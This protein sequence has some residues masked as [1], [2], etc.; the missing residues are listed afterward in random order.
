MLLTTEK[1]EKKSKFPQ[2]DTLDFYFDFYFNLKN[3]WVE[4]TEWWWQKVSLYLI[5]RMNSSSCWKSGW[6]KKAK[7]FTSICIVGSR[8]KNQ[9][10]IR[11]SLENTRFSRLSLAPRAGLEPATS[12]L[13]VMRSTDWANEECLNFEEISNSF[14]LP[15][16]LHCLSSAS[17]EHLINSRV[18]YR[19]SY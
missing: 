3:T 16:G 12:W 7:Y 1:H 2:I 17:L 5:C 19:L 11:K 9:R 15:T 4:P 6:S 18:L 13:T 14:A 8:I 10:N